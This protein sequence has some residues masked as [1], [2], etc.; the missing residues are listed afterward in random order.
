M[1]VNLEENTF[2]KKAQDK[3]TE[4]KIEELF[5]KDKKPQS[6]VKQEETAA[7]ETVDEQDTSDTSEEEEQKV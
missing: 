4:Q 7:Y 6:K 1:N 3:E 5:A 2:S